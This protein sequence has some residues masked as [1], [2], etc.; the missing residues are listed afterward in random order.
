[1]FVAV[2]CNPSLNTV[3]YINIRVYKKKQLCQFV[4]NY[5]Y[6]QQINNIIVYKKTNS[7]VIFLHKK[8]FGVWIWRSAQLLVA[9]QQQTRRHMSILIRKRIRIMMMTVFQ[10]V[11]V[12]T[13]LCVGFIWQLGVLDIVATEERWQRRFRRFG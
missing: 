8:Q 9:V 13:I 3:T 6:L 11:I 12:K 4:P 7:I 1:M 5:K 2:I 10:T